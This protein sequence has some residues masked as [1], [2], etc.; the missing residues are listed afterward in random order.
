MN[1]GDSGFL[2]QVQHK[3]PVV[4]DDLSLRRGRPQGFGAVD[5]EVERP[6]RVPHGESGYVAEQLDDQI[7]SLAVDLDAV[8]NE[9]PITGEGCDRRGLTDRRR[10]GG[11]LRLQGV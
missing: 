4:P 1:G 7:S 9:L 5:E 3:V 11:T 10:A 6:L 2:E 8:G